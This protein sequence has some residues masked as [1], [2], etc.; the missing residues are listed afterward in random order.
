[1]SHENAVDARKRE[2]I[3]G[4]FARILRHLCEQWSNCPAG[5]FP[6]FKSPG[7]DPPRNHRA[8]ERMSSLHLKSPALLLDFNK[9]WNA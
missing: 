8:Q 9:S 6:G 4:A 7:D 1:M 5:K 3:Y 2:V